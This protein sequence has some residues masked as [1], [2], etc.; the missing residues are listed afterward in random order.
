MKKGFFFRDRIPKKVQRYRCSHC[1][2]CFSAQTF[3]VDY[4]LRRPDLLVP[5][6]HRL[7]SC[8]GFRQIAREFGVSHSTIRGLSDRL[9]RHCLLFQEK[10]RPK[11]CPKEPLILDGFRT[12][13]HSQYWPMDLNLVVGQSLFVYGFNDAELRRSGAMRP[14]QKEKRLLLESK[15]GRPDPRATQRQVE[16]LLR[17]IV[18]KGGRVVLRTD[19]HQA[20]PRSIA[21]LRDRF[22]KHEQTSS[23]AARTTRNPL[24]PV[25]L[26]DMLLR[27]CGSNHKRE[28]IAF[29]KRRQSILYRAAVWTVW[30]NFMKD[31]SENTKKGTPAMALGVTERAMRVEEILEERLFPGDFGLSRWL[32]DCYFGRI[33]TRAIER[34]KEHQARFAV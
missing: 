19:E 10:W 9:G 27:H 12:F 30:R 5:T 4:W 8:S 16:K 33:P 23:K 28:T 20:Y 13:E 21:S 25:N 26:S 18:P 3:A 6:F 32:S 1:G 22:F 14:K 11:S 17:S 7:V 34:C 2:R 31:R 24:F 29:S 15:F